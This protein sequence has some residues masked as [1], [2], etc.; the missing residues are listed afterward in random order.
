MK[1]W[2]N[3]TLI[4]LSGFGAATAVTWLYIN[5]EVNRSDAEPIDL[6]T[7]V[8]VI[9]PTYNE[10]SYVERSL[11]SLRE[12]TLVKAY[13]KNFELIVVDSYSRDRTVEKA[14]PYADKV[15]SAP[16]GVLNARTLAISQSIGD[17]IVAVNADTFYP[18]NFLNILLRPFADQQV[19]G[20]MSLRLHEGL[21]APL[22]MW[23]QLAFPRFYGSNSAFRRWAY[24]RIGGFNL[25]IDQS[26]S[27]QLVWAEEVD[28]MERLSKIG[29]VLFEPKAPVFT[30]TR[31]IVT[32]MELDHTSFI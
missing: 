8:S 25:N 6:Q 13:P 4:G 12:Q 15:I 26:K 30:S 18:V 11:R 1:T 29:K 28:F 3:L 27:D 24:Y 22:T 5:S 17:I 23:Y 10:E 21:L 32:R 9:M 19:V 16:R 14:K 31:R 20:V 2:Q 7:N